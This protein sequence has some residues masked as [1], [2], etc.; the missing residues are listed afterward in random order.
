MSSKHVLL[1]VVMIVGAAIFHGCEA[2]TAAPEDHKAAKP[3]QTQ[4]EAL[5]LAR[6]QDLPAIRQADRLVIKM[7]SWAGSKQVVVR[8]PPWLAKINSALVLRQ[9][10]PSGGENWAALTWYKGDKEIRAAWVFNYGEWGFERPSTDW[11]LGRNQ[12]LVKVIREALAEPKHRP[13]GKPATRPATQPGVDQAA[14]WKVIYGAEEDYRQLAGQEVILRGKLVTDTVVLGSGR[15][16]DSYTTEFE[17]VF[18]EAA[19]RRIFLTGK[20]GN[21]GIDDLV[22]YRV[23]IRGKALDSKDIANTTSV[24]VG[25]VRLIGRPATQ[26]AAGKTVNGLRARI[27]ASRYLSKRLGLEV[28]VGFENVSKANLAIDFGELQALSWKIT[29]AAGKEVE[30]AKVRRAEPAPVWHSMTPG[31]SVGRILGKAVHNRD[32]RLKIGFYEWKLKPGRYSIHCLLSLQSDAVGKPSGQT[33][34]RGK[35]ELPPA[36]FEVIGEVSDKDLIEAG[37][38]VRAAHPAGGLAMWRALA[39]LVRPGMTVRQMYLVLPPRK[40]SLKAGVLDFPRTTLWNGQSFFLTYWLD[41][42]FGVEASGFGNMGGRTTR[43]SGL[44]GDEYMVLTSTPRIKSL[45]RPSTQP[46][47]KPGEQRKFEDALIF[48]DNHLSGVKNGATGTLSS[49]GWIE[50]GPPG[51]VSKVSWQYLRTIGPGDVYLMTMAF[52]P[53][54]PR[55]TPE[56]RQVTYAGVPLVVFEGNNQRVVLLMRRLRNVHRDGLKADD[57]LAL[58]KESRSREVSFNMDLLTTPAA[59]PALV[60][61]V[62]DAEGSARMRAVSLLGRI[63]SRD[64]RDALITALRKTPQPDAY[65]G[66]SMRDC[67]V[68]AIDRCIEREPEKQVIDDLGHGHPEVRWLAAMQLG[69]RKSAAAVPA[70]I[71]LLDDK[72]PVRL[73]A[74]WALGEIGDVRGDAV[75]FAIVEGRRGGGSAGS[76]IEAMGKIGTARAL[77]AVKSIKPDHPGYWMARKVL[78]GWGSNFRKPTTRPATQPARRQR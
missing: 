7:A 60:A 50:C 52:P 12:A 20:G 69:R 64:A 13:A 31:Y 25:W 55:D 37:K 28:G 63:G 1:I 9:V 32:G 51:A 65:A 43:P 58:L 44:I 68:S 75:L 19:N 14:G 53:V 38:Q 22:G 42:A 34:W 40:M 6:E 67:L 73:G 27:K 26:P 3:A 33:G 48:V 77:A 8:N 11:T 56:R 29:D 39:K 16:D 45:R 57:A 47:T 54:L 46:A 62:R 76:A 74:T 72:H 49:Q 21:T 15:K 18:L 78:A 70:L 36:E 35:I 61:V 59:V 71:A 66:S 41:D 23:E 5:R 2:D 10:S 24:R 17:G 30:P 4:G